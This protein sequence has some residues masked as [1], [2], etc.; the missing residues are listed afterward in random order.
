METTCSTCEGSLNL[1]NLFAESLDVFLL[2]LQT[3]QLVDVVQ[4][5]SVVLLVFY[6][7]VYVPAVR[8]EY[9]VGT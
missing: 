1:L 3:G 5:C 8:S 6:L 2:L 7:D 9:V 4:C